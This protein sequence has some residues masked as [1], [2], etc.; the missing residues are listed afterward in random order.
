MPMVAT[1]EWWPATPS[2][3]PDVGRMRGRKFVEAEKTAPEIAREA[4][5]LIGRAVCG[6]KT[7][8]GCVR[9]RE[10]RVAAD[11]VGA[12]AGGTTTASC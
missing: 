4:V 2:R 3:V 1:T 12:G 10:T 9:R 6:G 11:A 8:Q 5:D 7:G